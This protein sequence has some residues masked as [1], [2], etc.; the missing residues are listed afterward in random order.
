[1]IKA[2]SDVRK[3]Q[4]M[5]LNR[6]EAGVDFSHSCLALA[7]PG[8]VEESALARPLGQGLWD[9]AHLSHVPV[10]ATG[11]GTMSRPAA[12]RAQS[13]RRRSCHPRGRSRV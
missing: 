4:E 5:K 11:A 13:S 12:Y 10:A 3:K 8:R 7:L 2:K 6:R 9:G 1:M